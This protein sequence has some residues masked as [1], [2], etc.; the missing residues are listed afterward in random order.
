MDTFTYKNL[1]TLKKWRTVNVVHNIV[2][3]RE[4]FQT[5]PMPGRGHETY[6]KVKCDLDFILTS[7]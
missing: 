5:Q 7:E 2:V 3:N 4:L 1:D 6:G